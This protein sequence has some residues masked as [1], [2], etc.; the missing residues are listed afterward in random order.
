MLIRFNVGNFLSFNELQEF[1]M[2]AGKVRNKIDHLNDD[3][4]LKL[5]KFGAIFGANASGKSNLVKAMNFTETMITKGFPDNHT[6]LYFRLNDE[7]KNKPSYFEF[8]IKIRE[9]YYAYGFEVVLNKSNLISEWLY[10]ILPNNEQKMIFN[11]NIK[12]GEFKYDIAFTNK[13][14]KTRMEV[15]SND[16]KSMSNVLF[17]NEMNRNKSEIY[18]EK[19]ELSIF[20]D[21]FNWFVS[22]L[23]INY[24]NR[25]I[26]N[27]S[28]FQNNSNNIEICEIIKAFG[29]GITNFKIVE[30][31]IEELAKSLPRN[32]LKDIISKLEEDLIKIPEDNKKDVKNKKVSVM[33][34][35]NESFFII[36]ENEKQEFHVKTIVFEH[37]NK[38]SIFSINEESDGTRRILD[39]I[40][41]LVSEEKDKVF[42]I[43]EVDR[44][45]HP[46][47]TY[48]FIESF[49]NISKT[50]KVQLIVTTHESRLLDFDLLRRD[51]IW[52]MD[53]NKIGETSLYSLD[54]YNERFDK[55]I[56]KAYLEGRYGGVP[57]FSSVF[58]VKED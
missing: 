36:D 55:K 28:Y 27:Y 1:S 7:N 34:R 25:P 50:K 23:D 5:L 24:P 38:N 13:E 30:S 45:L 47:L 32:I 15:Y 35:S 31:S 9:K 12:D 22:K 57:I 39:L 43:D 20:R 51:E 56:D 48:K 4:K 3:G 41:I 17:L 33:L 54:A 46:Q 29:T 26:S 18:K 53:K 16:I 44:S 11:R 52:F 40:E 37:G 14:N 58:P 10:E 8:E 21:V 49:Q 6:N 2:I 19:T 42:I